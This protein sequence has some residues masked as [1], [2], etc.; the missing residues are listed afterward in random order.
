MQRDVIIAELQNI[1][2]LVFK[3]NQ[4]VIS[5]EMTAADHE[6]WDS[7]GHIH[8]IV[9]VEKHFKVHLS[10]AEVARLTK[11]G[12]LIDLLQSKVTRAA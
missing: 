6:A 2:R 11:V 3:D 12:D 9:A 5:S 1:F 10:N 4:I 7:L 8:L